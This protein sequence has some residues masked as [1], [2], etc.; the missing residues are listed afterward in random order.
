MLDKAI[1][2]KKEHRAQYRGSK[3]FDTHCRNHGGCDYCRDSRTYTKRRGEEAQ[4]DAL[5]EIGQ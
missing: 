1:Q 4:R 5:K 3:Q 2:H